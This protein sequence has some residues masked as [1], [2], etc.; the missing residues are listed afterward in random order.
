ML[1]RPP[2]Q[3]RLGDVFRSLE[4]PVTTA[5]CISDDDYCKRSA[6]CAARDVWVQVEAAVY[7]VL[8]AI[9][10]ADLVKRAKTHKSDYQI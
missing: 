4:G 5:E 10:L 6:D 2:K 3:I 7:G 8:D 9:T 1:A